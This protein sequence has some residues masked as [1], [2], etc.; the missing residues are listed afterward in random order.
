MITCYA[1]RADNWT[2]SSGIR[3]VGKH[4]EFDRT[5]KAEYERCHLHLP[6]LAGIQWHWSLTMCSCNDG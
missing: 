5:H 6:H 1:L 4:F 3:A 2:S